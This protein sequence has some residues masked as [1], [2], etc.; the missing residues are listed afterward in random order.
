MIVYS[1]LLYFYRA[2]MMSMSTPAKR[3]RLEDIPGTSKFQLK[4]GLSVTLGQR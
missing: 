4:S 1:S 2:P 3:A